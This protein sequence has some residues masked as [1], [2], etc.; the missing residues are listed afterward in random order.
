MDAQVVSDQILGPVTLGSRQTALHVPFDDFSHVRQVDRLGHTE[1]DFRLPPEQWQLLAGPDDTFFLYGSFSGQLVLGSKSATST[2]NPSV[3]S[4]PADS[5]ATE[6]RHPYSKDGFIARIEATGKVRWLR[7]FS[8]G[9]EQ[10]LT[11]VLVLGDELVLV[12]QFEARVFGGDL[13]LRS[14][15]GASSGAAFIARANLEGEVTQ[16]TPFEAA[17]IERVA[18]CDDGG[19]VVSGLALEPE[20]ES[21]RYLRALD[22]DGT[23]LWSESWPGALLDA[24]EVQCDDRGRV[25]TLLRADENR[26]GSLVYGETLSQ[27]SA[28]VRIDTEGEAAFLTRIPGVHYQLTL[29]LKPDRIGIAGSFIDAIDFGEGSI[30]GYG[31][32]DVWLAEF[33]LEGELVWGTTWGGPEADAGGALYPTDDGWLL[34]FYTST[35]L[36]LGTPAVDLP[37]GEHLMWIRPTAAE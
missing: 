32:T 27:E 20:S 17:S 24:V 21:D 33:D 22:A 28:L 15:F 18:V 11:H 37:V 26:D 13:E 23:E 7:T 10:S 19:V 14:R 5:Y 35:A 4:G 12:G 8:G 16:L 1:F 30:A 3:Q 36:Q 9:G 34:A 29:A 2:L 31:N 25:Y 6:A